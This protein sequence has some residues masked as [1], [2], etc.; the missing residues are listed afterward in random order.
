MFNHK[1]KFILIV[2][3][4]FGSLIA[5]VEVGDLKEDYHAVKLEDAQSVEARFKISAGE[6]SLKGGAKD[7]MEGYFEYNID[8]WKPEVDYF[9][10]GRTGRLNV[11]QTGKTGIPV[12]NSKNRW[13]VNLSKNV[14]ID[15]NLDFGA[16]EGHLDLRGIDLRDLDIDMGVGELTIDLT[17]ELKA[18]LRVTIDGG[19]GSATIYLSEN[20]GVRVK[21]DGGIGSVDA[22]GL[23]KNDHIYTND[24]YGET[25]IT[26][27]I[28]IDAGIGS[29]DLRL[30]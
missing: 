7:L 16:G 6:L 5:C 2:T 22:P 27:D 1:L 29:I 3:F 15:L 13:D 17:G 10:S 11:K 12:G 28:E 18:D 21:V 30:K 19:I 9:V 8:Q 23:N 4:M 25:E 24:A 20:V 14:P 26:I